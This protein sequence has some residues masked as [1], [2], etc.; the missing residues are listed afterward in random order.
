MGLFRTR[1]APAVEDGAYT[2]MQSALL[3]SPASSSAAALASPT[4]STA[5]SPPALTAGGKGSVFKRMRSNL[6]RVMPARRRGA[7]QDAAASQDSGAAQ[8]EAERQRWAA[9]RQMLLADCTS[10]RAEAQ[11]LAERLEGWSSLLRD[12]FF[13]GG[14]HDRVD[15]ITHFLCERVTP[16]TAASAQPASQRPRPCPSTSHHAI[17]PSAAAARVCGRDR[18]RLRSRRA[19]RNPRRA[20]D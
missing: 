16:D 1:G 11:A 5:A 18:R 14:L 20:A 15:E 4:S 9:E 7:R 3:R 19:P 17:H 8:L 13:Y 12:I 6:G 2:A 10:I